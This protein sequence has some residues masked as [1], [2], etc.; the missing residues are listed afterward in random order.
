MALAQRNHALTYDEHEALRQFH[1]QSPAPDR[2]DPVWGYLRS[3]G[4]VWLDADRE[5]QRLPLPAQPVC[6]AGV[7]S[8][9]VGPWIGRPP[10]VRKVGPRIP[11]SSPAGGRHRYQHCYPNPVHSVR[12][13]LKSTPGRW[14]PRTP[15]TRSVN[16]VR[17]SACRR[18]NGG[19]AAVPAVSIARDLVI[20]ARRALAPRM[21]LGRSECP[22]A[23]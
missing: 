17:E 5:G 12:G 7:R 23:P 9:R 19:L 13:V 1:A 6:G 3:L 10:R 21:R 20:G 14:K 15:A 2:D 22:T 4:L 11:L 18:A 8:D 16:R